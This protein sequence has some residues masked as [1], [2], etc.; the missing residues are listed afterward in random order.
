VVSKSASGAYFSHDGIVGADSSYRN[1]GYGFD[2]QWSRPGEPGLFVLAEYLGGE[3]AADNDISMT[4]IQALAA[5]NIRMKNP[6]AFLY[7]VEPAFRVDVADPNTDVDDNGSTLF[8]AVLGLYFSSRAQW[9]IAFE[10]QSFQASGA[11]SISGMRTAFTVS[12]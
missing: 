5:Y 2:A 9:R 8:T 1:N 6:D 12:F 3:D 7:A 10:N 4:G 11:S